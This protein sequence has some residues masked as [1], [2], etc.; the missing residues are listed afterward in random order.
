MQ[1]RWRLVPNGYLHVAT[2]WETYAHEILETLSAE[3]LL[4]NT[5]DGFAP[6]PAYRPLTKFEA[7]GLALGHHV[8]DL[9]FRRR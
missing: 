4:V 9:C 8:R 2:D 3:P 6:R 5:A 7:R 1:P